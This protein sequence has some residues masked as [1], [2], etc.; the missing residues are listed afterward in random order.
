MSNSDGGRSSSPAQI[1]IQSDKEDPNPYR[2]YRAVVGVNQS[3]L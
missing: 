3:F 1:L 2:R